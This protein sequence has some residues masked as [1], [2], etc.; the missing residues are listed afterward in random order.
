MKR[1]ANTPARSGA[2]THQQAQHN[3]EEMVRL[4]CAETEAFR[5]KQDCAREG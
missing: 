5:Q 3:R 4:I 1:L 2:T